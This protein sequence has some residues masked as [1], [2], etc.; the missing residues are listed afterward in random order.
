MVIKYN[1]KIHSHNHLIKSILGRTEY[2][3][4]GLD[5]PKEELMVVNYHGTQKKFIAN[6][7]RQLDF[8]LSYFRIISPSDVPS[9]FEGSLKSNAPC[10]LINFDDGIKNNLYAVDVMN[11]LGIKAFFFV[12]PDYIDSPIE[13]Q[14]EYFIKN[15]RP[16]INTNID[17]EKE[18]LISM[19]WNELKDL[20]KTGH[21]IGSHSR[22]HSMVA[23]NTTADS[24]HYEIETSKSRIAEMLNVRSSS[25]D[26]YCSPNESSLST[27]KKE[28]ELIR[29]NY[30]FFYS[31]YPGSNQKDK[32]PFFI[33]RSNVESHWTMGALLYAINRWDRKRWGKKISTFAHST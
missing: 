20:Q 13:K 7:K 4:S 6:F 10:L 5:H 31:S 8:F 9:Y 22:T 3:F 16:V 17:R 30:C 15:I 12:V 32:N 26:S 19:T 25:I 29:N 28:M 18:D 14:K 1:P 11:A 27:G 2:F 21:S 23:A 24:R 33:K